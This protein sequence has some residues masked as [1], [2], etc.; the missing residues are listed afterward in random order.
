MVKGVIL[1]ADYS[2]FKNALSIGGIEIP[3]EGSELVVGPYFQH[4]DETTEQPDYLPNG[5]G[6]WQPLPQDIEI[7][8]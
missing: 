6:L 5:I 7:A 2:D 1:S 3:E 8:S 4:I